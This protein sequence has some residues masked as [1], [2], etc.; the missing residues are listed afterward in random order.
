MPNTHTHTPTHTQINFKKIKN[1]K[2]KKNKIK[3][4]NQPAAYSRLNSVV[5]EGD[6]VF[7][8]IT[9]LIICY[10]TQADPDI[11]CYQ[12]ILNGV[13]ILLQSL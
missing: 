4:T 5:F 3:T 9:C 13:P 10:K 6:N 11:L 12:F 7:C 1:K 2:N 8:R